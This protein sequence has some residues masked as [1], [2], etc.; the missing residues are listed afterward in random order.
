MAV[1]CLNSGVESYYE[2]FWD[3]SNEAWPCKETLLVD[4]LII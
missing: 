1:R 4:R 2:G 3:R